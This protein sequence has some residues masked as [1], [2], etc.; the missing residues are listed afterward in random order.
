MEPYTDHS[1]ALERHEQQIK[2][3][4][5]RQEEL[6]R[7]TQSVNDLALSVRGMV[8]KLAN[9]EARVSTIEDEHRSRA[10]TIWACVATGIIGAAVAWLMA[11]I[12]K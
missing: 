3:L 2:T 4:F 12:L 9:M 6:D 1:V 8:E 5:R 7:L 11:G 10:R